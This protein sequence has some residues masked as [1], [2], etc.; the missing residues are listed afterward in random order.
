[1]ADWIGMDYPDAARLLDRAGEHGCTKLGSPETSDTEV[2]HAQVEMKLLRRTTWPF[3]R[4]VRRCQLER[5]LERRIS[6]VYLTP[7]G[8][9]DIQLPI[10][11]I[12]VEARKRRRVGAIEYNGA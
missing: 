6:D 4:E 5:Q 11:E 9:T 1:M 12:C 3:R 10:Q 8:I 2:R 7:F